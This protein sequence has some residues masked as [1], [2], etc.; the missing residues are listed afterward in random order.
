MESPRQR[1]YSFQF[2]F[3]FSA[4]V[5]ISTLAQNNKEVE[6]LFASL[7]KIQA[8]DPQDFQNQLNQ[9][10]KCSFEEVRPMRKNHHKWKQ[11]NQVSEILLSLRKVFGNVREGLREMGTRSGVE[12]EPPSQT[13]LVDGTMNV[14]GVVIS[15]VPG[16]NSIKELTEYKLV[17]TTP[18]SQF[19]LTNLAH[20]LWNNFGRNPGSCPWYL[21]KTVMEFEWNLPTHCNNS[22]S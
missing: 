1:W 2:F 21:E 6:N 10:G 12:I 16:G 5:V 17:D 22:T 11:L 9:C 13:K 4:P 3:I 14:P 20:N 7:H 18:F 19:V 8:K 15:G